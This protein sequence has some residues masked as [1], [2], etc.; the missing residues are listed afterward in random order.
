MAMVR[1]LVLH[2]MVEAS[3]ISTVEQISVVPSLFVSVAVAPWKTPLTMAVINE[4]AGDPTLG[5]T[6]KK[7]GVKEIPVWISCSYPQNCRRSS[8]ISTHR[9]EWHGTS[10]PRWIQSIL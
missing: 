8:S 9:F 6:L 7:T 10:Y 5:E 1:A 4:P 2:W 3:V